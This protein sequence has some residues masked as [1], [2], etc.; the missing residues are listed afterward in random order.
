MQSLKIITNK[1]IFLIKLFCTVFT[2]A[3]TEHLR[4]GHL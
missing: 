4:L 2:I 3:I 1:Y